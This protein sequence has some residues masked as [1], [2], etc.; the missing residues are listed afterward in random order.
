MSHPPLVDAAT[1][2]CRPRAWTALLSLLVPVL[3]T[4]A[5]YFHEQG[6]V[7][8]RTHVDWPLVQKRATGILL[9]LERNDGNQGKYLHIS[10]WA[11]RTDEATGWLQPSVLIVAPDGQATEFRANLRARPDLAQL[12]VSERQRNMAGFE[13]RLKKRYF[14]A[15]QPLRVVLAV[16]QKGQRIYL[17]TGATV[18]DASS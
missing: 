18:A 8:H 1:G 4:A 5:F 9:H 13:V 17:D 11:I 15:G 10:G 2:P 7:Q 14:P 12:S 3:L 6:V 16:T